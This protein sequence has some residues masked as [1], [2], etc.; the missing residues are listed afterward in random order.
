L[1]GDFNAEPSSAPIQTALTDWTDAT[2]A[3]KTCPAHKPRIKIDYVF[4]RPA[5]AWR[6]VETRVVDEP[7]ASDHRPVWVVFEAVAVQ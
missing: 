1:A 4:Y 6:V 7:M 5:A 2:S 3:E